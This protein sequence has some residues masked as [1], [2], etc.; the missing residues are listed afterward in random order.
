MLICGRQ[1]I[2][3]NSFVDVNARV[4]GAD[5]SGRTLDAEQDGGWA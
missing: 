5:D 1:L 4:M 3:A 2:S